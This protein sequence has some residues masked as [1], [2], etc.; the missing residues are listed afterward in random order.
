MAQVKWIKLDISMFDNRKIK[1]IKS[2]PEGSSIILIWLQLLCLAG[3]VN[4]N[5]KIYLTDEI[6]YTDQMLATLFDEPLSTIQLALKTFEQFNMVEMIDNIIYISN[7]EKYQN[8][9]GM[10]KIREQTRKRVANYREKQKMLCNVTSNATVTDGNATDIDI[11][12][13]IDNKKKNIKKKKF[14]APTL[15]EITDYCNS[16]NNNVNPKQ[17]FDYYEANDWVDGKG[18]KVKS[19]KQKVITWEKGNQNNKRPDFSMPKYD[20]EWGC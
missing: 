12:I 15:E 9:D 6:A 1:L 5:G 14:V 7:W 2:L 3:T 10:E 4:D 16:R 20:D 19:W 13:D 8:V 11:E 17:F 18:N